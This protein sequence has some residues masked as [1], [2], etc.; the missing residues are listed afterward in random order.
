MKKTSI[1]YIQV[2]HLSKVYFLISKLFYF[3][4]KTP[5]SHIQPATGTYEDWSPPYI[6]KK[7]QGTKNSKKIKLSEGLIYQHIFEKNAK[8]RKLSQDQKKI[9][10]GQ[11]FR[12]WIQ[13]VLFG[14]CD[15]NFLLFC[16]FLKI[17]IDLQIIFIFY[18][19]CCSSNFLDLYKGATNL[20][21]CR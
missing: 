13:M 4:K 6:N 17:Y 14:Y 7:S 12:I 11:F 20:H 18:E 5:I 8:K 3:M 15:L 19:I 21:M 9:F 16:I 2:C 10:F 1:L